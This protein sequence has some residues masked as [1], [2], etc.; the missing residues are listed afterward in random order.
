MEN[1]IGY[2]R[3]FSLQDLN[4]SVCC[5][6][7]G[8]GAFGDFLLARI[9]GYLFICG[10]SALMRGVISSGGSGRCSGPWCGGARAWVPVPVSLARGGL[11][12]CVQGREN[13]A[14]AHASLSEVYPAS[15]FQWHFTYGF[16]YRNS[17]WLLFEATFAVLKEWLI[18]PVGTMGL[19]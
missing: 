10:W 9:Y 1:D 18:V 7:D 17:L 5:I 2:L 4:V 16:D 8:A 14:H 12:G 6:A 3:S 15:K 13:G 11:V 19:C